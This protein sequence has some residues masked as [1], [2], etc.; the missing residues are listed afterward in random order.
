LGTAD[1]AGEPM[2]TIFAPIVVA[3]FTTLTSAARADAPGALPEGPGARL[4]DGFYLRMAVG[5]GGMSSREHVASDGTSE[6]RLNGGGGA[7]E[8]SIGG[9]LRPGFVVAGTLYAQSAMLGSVNDSTGTHDMHRMTTFALI[10]AT[11]DVYPRPRDGFHVLGTLGPA[12]M[13]TIEDDRTNRRWRSNSGGG[14]SIGGGYDWW[15]GPQWSLGFLIRFT[16]ARLF[17]T[18]ELDGNPSGAPDSQR[19]VAMVSALFTALY[20]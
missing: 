8:T 7:F 1:A 4:H 12:F 5:G 6:P 3:V 18:T 14:L 15:V 17:G 9:S 11:V 20:H 13:T 16:G 2:R 19:N 10:G